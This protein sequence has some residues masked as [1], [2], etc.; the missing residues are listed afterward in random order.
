MTK[1][2]IADVHDLLTEEEFRT[3]SYRTLCDTLRELQQEPKD[4]KEIESLRDKCRRYRQILGF[5]DG[6]KKNS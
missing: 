5:R 4:T 2:E 6:T 1:Q 3:A